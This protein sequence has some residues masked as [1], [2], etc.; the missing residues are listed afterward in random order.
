MQADATSGAAAEASSVKAGPW[1]VKVSKSNLNQQISKKN[2]KHVSF[3]ENK[4]ELFGMIHLLQGLSHWSVQS[5][6]AL[7]GRRINYNLIDLG[8]L[9]ASRGTKFCV[10]STSFQRY[11]IGWPQQPLTEKVLKFNKILHDSTTKKVVSK[12][13][14]KAESKC[15]DDSE[16]LSI[17]FPGLKNSAALMTSVA[18]T[19]SMASMTSTASFHQKIYWSWWFDHP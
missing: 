5:K 2:Q 4:G 1:F 11:D 19:A 13:K 16:V 9:V 3:R 10:S 12:H 14:I 17:D 6:S 7:A 15:L 18:S 8:C